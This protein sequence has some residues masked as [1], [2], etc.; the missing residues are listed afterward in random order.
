[1]LYRVKQFFKAMTAK[2]TANEKNFIE[3]YLN[4]DERRLFYSLPEYEQAHC[5][6]VAKDVLSNCRTNEEKQCVLVKAALLHDIG[7]L[8][9]GLNIITKS[10]MVLLD[11]SMPGFVSRFKKFKMVDT[12]YNHPEKAFL[13][14]KD[15]GDYFGY[16][17]RNH[18]NYS[19]N[20]DEGLKLLQDADSRN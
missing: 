3:F 13:Y 17:I 18:H 7:K 19:M 8:A 5:L 20:G 14:I 11:K 12:Y 2:I 1:M 4:E 15:Q 6:R 16:L 9:G 10:I